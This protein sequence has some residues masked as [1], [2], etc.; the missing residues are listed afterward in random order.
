MKDYIE[1]VK[2]TESIDL[3]S[4]HD[5]ICPKR[6][7]RLLHAGMG[8]CTEAGEFVDILKKFIFYGKEIDTVNAVEELGDLMWYIGVA[9]DE[10]GVSFEE[11]MEKNIN[12]LRTRYAKAEFKD[13]AA[14]NRDLSAE[15]K[16]LE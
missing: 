4:I 3:I 16:V 13:T 7:T 10:L 12:K 14:K 8:M 11:V 9:C 1:K 6:T 15:R 5:R 2:E